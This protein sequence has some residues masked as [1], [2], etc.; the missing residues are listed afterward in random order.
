M[1][2]NLT[3]LC[4]TMKKY[5]LTLL[6]LEGVEMVMAPQMPEYPD[7]KKMDSDLPTDE[8]ILENPYH[9]LEG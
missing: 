2:V 5:N 8:Q 9:G 7:F 3:E 4:E 1:T 6:K